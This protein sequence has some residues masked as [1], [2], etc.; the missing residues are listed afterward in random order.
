MGGI[1][2]IVMSPDDQLAAS[3]DHDG[4][5][6]IREIKEGGEIK[7]TIQAGSEVWSVSVSFSPNGEKFAAAVYDVE[8]GHVIRV[9]DVETGELTLSPIEGHKEWIRCV[10]WSLDGCRLFSASDDHSIRCWTSETGKLIG[11]PWM[12]HTNLVFSRPP[13][14]DGTKLASASRD[15]TVRFWDA[16]SGEPIEQPLQ[17]GD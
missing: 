4:K 3:G 16:H 10:L 11:Q 12:G 17:H 14:P 1:R 8:G 13:S 6:V 15:N 2:C 9:Y 5:I 7:H